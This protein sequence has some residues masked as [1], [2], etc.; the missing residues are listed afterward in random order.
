MIEPSS[1]ALA[2][3]GAMGA[4]LLAR[5][6]CAFPT[7]HFVILDPKETLSLVSP[8]IMHFRESGPFCAALLE[9]P[10]DALILAVKPQTLE[11][12]IR[13]LILS[14][15]LPIASIAAGI[16]L[17]HLGALLPGHP[18]MRIMPNLPATIG[19][20]VSAL[21]G[22]RIPAVEAA[23]AAVGM[24]EW[25]ES[26]DDMDAITALAGSGPA[27]VFFLT[28]ILEST[29]VHLGLAPDRAARLAR[30]TVEGAAALMAA[31]EGEAPCALRA[32]VTSKGGTT[33]AAMAI[34]ED[35]RME[36]LFTQALCAAVQR[37][38]T[39]T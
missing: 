18:V 2:G 29:G 16:T 15:R 7:A 5:W 4:A 1:L 23:F 13:S 34:L 14:P 6:H 22:A 28:E 39:L 12:L 36:V 20:G 9:T 30:K 27:Y 3:C 11:D 21:I 33:A 37:S 17:R 25:L 10:P 26:E 32:A 35:G 31:R 38:K 19:Q 8:R 24:V